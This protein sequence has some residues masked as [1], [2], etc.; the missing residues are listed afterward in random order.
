LKVRSGFSRVRG[1]KRSSPLI[2]P[3]FSIS[4]KLKTVAQWLRISYSVRKKGRKRE[5]A[6]GFTIGCK[7]EEGEKERK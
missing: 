2:F 3:A 6:S 1:F 5:E 4:A 7:E